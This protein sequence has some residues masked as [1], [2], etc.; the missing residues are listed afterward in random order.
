[1]Y[2]FGVTKWEG[3]D[4]VDLKVVGEGTVILFDQV[5]ASKVLEFIPYRSTLQLKPWTNNKEQLFPVVDGF[6]MTT[7]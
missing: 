4:F 6:M 1:M 7:E 3:N 2:N 5:D